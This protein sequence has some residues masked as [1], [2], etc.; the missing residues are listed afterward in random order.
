MAGLFSESEIRSRLT[1]FRRLM[2]DHDLDAFLVTDAEN[3]RYLTGFTGDESW[4]YVP[5]Q[6]RPRLLTDW[7]R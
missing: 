3:V 1:R 4:L 6:G 5:G 7:R 2:R